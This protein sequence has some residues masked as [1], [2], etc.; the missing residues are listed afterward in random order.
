MS[1]TPQNLRSLLHNLTDNFHHF[2]R[3]NS[4]WFPF[5]S[6]TAEVMSWVPR[7]DIEEK[8]DKYFITADL[9]GVEAKDIK[10]SLDNNV[11]VIEG[12][13]NIE[14]IQD[15]HSYSRMERFS[16]TFSRRFTLPTAVDETQVEAVSKL[17]VIRITLP[18]AA[19]SAHT[20]FIE[21]KTADEVY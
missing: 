20:R 2:L 17:G 21:V 10:I 1:L 18:K 13:R 4:D 12:Q 15:E 11:L 6:S 19:K 14:K 5:E 16:G 8:A 9:P 3:N 7:V